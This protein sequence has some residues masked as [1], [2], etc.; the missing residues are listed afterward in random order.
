M[1]ALSWGCNRLSH[2]LALNCEG[3][4]GF[5]VFCHGSRF[6]RRGDFK[7]LE[8]QG[9]RQPHS[10]LR[11]KRAQ[12]LA[13]MAVMVP[14]LVIG[15]MGML[16][17]GRA[18]YY[19][20]AITNAVREGA[21]Y[22]ATPYYLGL[23]PSCPS[24]TNCTTPSNAAIVARVKNELYGTGIT[25]QDTNIQVLPDQPT[26]EGYITN[27]NGSQYAVTVQASYQF[28]F[29]TP[30]IGSLIG[31]PLTINTSSVFRSEY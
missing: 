14:F 11:K 4:R 20:I 16:D 27:G 2:R 8:R 22:A 7:R 5:H 18:F 3:V 25:L 26:R 23:N 29:I 31:D 6:A 9:M 12:A 10:R 21:R 1:R 24:P 19:Q 13:E 28:N 15:M 17:L 30:I